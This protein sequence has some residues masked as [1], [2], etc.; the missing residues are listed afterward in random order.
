[1]D[2]FDDIRAKLK[3]PL[4][5]KDF[6]APKKMVL[7]W[8]KPKITPLVP[9]LIVIDWLRTGVFAFS[10]IKVYCHDPL[11]EPV[12]VELCPVIWHQDKSTFLIVVVPDNK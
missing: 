5:I 9:P 11:V 6:D 4:Y 7:P 3:L 10:T 2:E 12:V 8:F 1:M